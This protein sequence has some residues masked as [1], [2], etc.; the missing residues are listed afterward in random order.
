MKKKGADDARMCS[1]AIKVAGKGVFS[2]LDAISNEAAIWVMNDYLK[3]LENAG[4]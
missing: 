3:T 4:A 1:R 2:K